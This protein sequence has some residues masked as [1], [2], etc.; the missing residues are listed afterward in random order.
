VVAAQH[1]LVPFCAIVALGS[2]EQG[3]PMSIRTVATMKVHDYD[4]M[5]EA[6]RQVRSI[7]DRLD[8]ILTWEIHGNREAGVFY[9]YEVF[10]SSEA[11]IDYETAVTEAGLRPVFQEIS[12]LDRYFTFDRID[13]AGLQQMLA[14]IGA[15]SLEEVTSA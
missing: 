15:I 6:V 11:L 9:T 7:V 4:R 12:E 8:G 2:E 5:T 10:E 1:A 14:G 13:H 3:I